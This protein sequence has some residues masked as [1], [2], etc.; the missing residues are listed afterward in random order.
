MVVYVCADVVYNDDV[1]Y[2]GC[3]E[4]VNDDVTIIQ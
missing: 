3:Y 1:R 2:V 4:F